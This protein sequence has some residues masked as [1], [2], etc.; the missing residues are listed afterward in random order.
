MKV[1][2]PENIGI[3]L[4]S[5]YVEPKGDMAIGVARTRPGG[6]TAAAP[7]LGYRGHRGEAQR[8]RWRRPRL[9]KNSYRGTM[10]NREPQRQKA[11]QRDNI[12]KP[13]MG[14]LLDATP[15]R[16]SCQRCPFWDLHARAHPASQCATRRAFYVRPMRQIPHGK[17][18]PES[19][20]RHD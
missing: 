3:I 6:R 11:R 7:D 13:T 17:R 14:R 12:R 10:M 9:Q 15:G 4:I 18:N 8:G 5:G 16:P 20:P 19:R 2:K 1:D